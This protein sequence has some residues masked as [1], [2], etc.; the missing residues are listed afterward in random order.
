MTATLTIDQAL[1]GY[2][3]GHKELAASLDLDPQSRSQMLLYSDLLASPTKSRKRTYLTGYPLKS[4]RRFVLARTWLA[5]EELRPG[6]VWTHSLIMDFQSMAVMDDPFALIDLF[7]HPVADRIS[8]FSNRLS[9]TNTA[10]GADR[11]PPH[12]GDTRTLF[13]LQQLYGPTAARLVRL[14]PDEDAGNDETLALALWRQMWP[15]LRRD[16][17][18]VTGPVARTISFDAECSL[19]FARQDNMQ[20]ERAASINTVSQGFALLTSDLWEQGPTE[21]R[22]FIGRYALEAS[23]PRQIV[24]GL[25]SLYD[26]TRHGPIE[27]RLEQIRALSETANLPRLVRDTIIDELLE[28]RNQIDLVA[29][30]GEYRN[31]PAPRGADDA[32]AALSHRS[33]IQ[34]GPVFMA[35]QPSK[36]GELGDLLFHVLV[37]RLSIGDLIDAATSGVDRLSLLGL[38]P[39]IGEL[40]E[41]WPALD[42]DRAMLLRKWDRPCSV[43]LALSLF[44]T[45]G[46][47]VT[48]CALES[49]QGTTGADLVAL[50]TKADTFAASLVLNWIVDHT[51]MVPDFAK[52]AAQAGTDFVDRIC[53]VY[54]DRAQPFQNAGPWGNAILI[55]HGYESDRLSTSGLVVGM[56][57]A[58]QLDGVDAIALATICY[59]RL[60]PS[61]QRNRLS[62]KQ[63]AFL[64]AALPARMQSPSLRKWIACAAVDKWY[65][66]GST[67]QAV[68]LAQNG[69][70]LHDMFEQLVARM[71]R[72]T[73]QR[74]HNART[75]PPA[76]HA[77]VHNHLKP[78]QA[79]KVSWWWDW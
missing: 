30:V 50:L 21:L 19:Q 48:E 28:A 8:E 70:A 10:Y 33:D 4:A 69:D 73:L 38:R 3:R 74:L 55:Q 67:S 12:P 54:I 47:E 44:E 7:R 49:G 41:F 42:H 76:I 27:K 77:K 66:A 14:L 5:G 13:A 61:V 64:R 20:A 59:D 9:V 1:H 32:A 25:A 79:K 26:I 22:S 72:P 36:P 56:S 43:P 75:L 35:T 18:F 37:R 2:S 31:L 16:F 39:E 65:G 46:G 24:P 51:A 62:Q 29:L 57:A 53:A 34:L 78:K 40:S 45:I 23:T 60:Y 63:D 11:P 15:A 6:S 58:F 52:C 68:N 71:D 17:A